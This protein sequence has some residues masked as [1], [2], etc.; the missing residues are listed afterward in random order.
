MGNIIYQTSVAISHWHTHACRWGMGNIYI[1][2]ERGWI[3]VQNDTIVQ[4]RW[5]QDLADIYED[6]DGSCLSSSTLSDNEDISPPHACVC[7]CW[8]YQPPTHTQVPPP[9]P[10]SKKHTHN[11]KPAR[12]PF[13][14][15]S[16]VFCRESI[17]ICLMI[18]WYSHCHLDTH[19]PW[20]C[21][22]CFHYN[23]LR[24]SAWRLEQDH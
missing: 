12:G 20:C 18:G 7:V 19:R 15:L 22:A 2:L 16:S 17:S 23:L 11:K 10:P 14:Y 9:P 6:W 21:H 24:T 4:N 13:R 1:R 3:Q 8:N 5:T